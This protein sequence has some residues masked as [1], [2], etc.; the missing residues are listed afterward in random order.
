VVYFDKTKVAKLRR[1]E[2][3]ALEA[4][5]G[6]HRIQVRMDWVRSLPVWVR[7]ANDHVTRVSFGIDHP[8]RQLKD[9]LVGWRAITNR[10]RGGWGLLVEPAEDRIG[11][12]RAD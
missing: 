10:T 1:G 4:Q 3:I 11:P 2:E 12:N 5:A 9:G 8:L 7:T 6:E